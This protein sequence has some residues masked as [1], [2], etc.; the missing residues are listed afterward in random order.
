MQGGNSLSNDFAKNLHIVKQ[1]EMSQFSIAFVS[2]T[3]VD[4]IYY[5]R[6][7]S[8]SGDLLFKKLRSYILTEAQL[9]EHGFPRA[10]STKPGHAI[11]KWSHYDKLPQI[12][13][14]YQQL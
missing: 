13:S 7:T 9:V 3:I 10:D 11:I 6:Y 14:E 2:S 5:H 8:G 4:Y 12:K 1:Y